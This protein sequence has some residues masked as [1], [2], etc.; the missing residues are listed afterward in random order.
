MSVR[1]W[2][3]KRTSEARGRKWAEVRLNGAR[4]KGMQH[5]CIPFVLL[6]RLYCTI[7]V[8]FVLVVEVP[9]VAVT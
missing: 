7:R 9:A 4:R 5:C 3:V 2:T 1:F 6:I 8:T